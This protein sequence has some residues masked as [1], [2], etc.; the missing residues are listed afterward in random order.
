MDLYSLPKDMLVKLV[1]EIREETKNEYKEIIGILIN[2]VE[3]ARHSKIKCSE[4][5][6]FIFVEQYPFSDYVKMLYK[7][8]DWIND[9]NDFKRCYFC[10]KYFCKQHLHKLEKLNRFNADLYDCNCNKKYH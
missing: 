7:S 8:E 9:I 4:C 2:S 6:I 1:S 5:D 3:N 10:C